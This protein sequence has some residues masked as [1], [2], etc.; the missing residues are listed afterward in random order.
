LPL[1][2]EAFEEDLRISIEIGD[3]SGQVSMPSFLAL[4][5]LESGDAHGALARFKESREAAAALGQKRNEAFA[6]C[7]MIRAMAASGAA[8]LQDEL[9]RLREFV[10]VLGDHDRQAL[11]QAM[12]KVREACAAVGVQFAA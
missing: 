11:K 10:A 1:A 2:I 5:Y 6:M 3:T 12:E 7:G 9:G 8:D 4:C